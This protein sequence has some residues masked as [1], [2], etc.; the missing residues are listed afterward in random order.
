MRLGRC[1]GY[2]AQGLC[3]TL[4]GASAHRTPMRRAGAEGRGLGNWQKVRAARPA[5][6]R[7]HGTGS[8]TAFSGKTQNRILGIA[9][10]SRAWQVVGL[11]ARSGPGA[12]SSWMHSSPGEHAEVT[13][14]RGKRAW[15]GQLEVNLADFTNVLN[16]P[17]NLQTLQTKEKAQAPP[18]SGLY[19]QLLFAWNPTQQTY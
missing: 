8:D 4:L 15:A 11:R 13:V 6:C 9:Q 19:G 14:G 17:L 1:K 12:H 5:C 7:A 2:C 18:L 16:S 10:K 3:A